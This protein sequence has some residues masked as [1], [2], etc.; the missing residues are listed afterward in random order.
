[1]M[2]GIYSAHP[3]NTTILF[4]S[5][6]LCYSLGYNTYVCTSAESLNEGIDALPSHAHLVL[7][8]EEEVREETMEHL[9]GHVPQTSLETGT[10]ICTTYTHT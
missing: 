4:L 5:C 7:G 2:L 1:M 3:Y 9:N 6:F 10:H 8:G